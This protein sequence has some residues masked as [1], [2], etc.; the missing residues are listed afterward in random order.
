MGGFMAALINLN[1]PNCGGKLQI[2]NDVDRFSCGYCGNEFIVERSGGII[3][4]QPVIEGLKEV[5]TGVD[6]TASELAIIRLKG[7]INALYQQRQQFI[8]TGSRFKNYSIGSGFM[9]AFLVLIWLVY[10]GGT[11][12]DNASFECIIFF[13]ALLFA[14]ISFGLYR[15]T[16][17]AILNK[18][19]PIDKM[20]AEKVQ[21]L[22]KHQAIVDGK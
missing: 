9:A 17:Q 4:L 22:K 21:E 2:S 5:K 10:L 13:G 8:N 6:K 1:C 14:F 15:K 16:K 3:T 18:T 19:S 7:E 20:I 12:P 11:E